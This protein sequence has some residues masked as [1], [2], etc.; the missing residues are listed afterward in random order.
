MAAEELFNARLVRKQFIISLEVL[1]FFESYF[2]RY[3]CNKDR[4][5]PTEEKEERLSG[6]PDLSWHEVPQHPEK[7]GFIKATLDYQEY[8]YSQITH[9]VYSGNMQ[10]HTYQVFKAA[11]SQSFINNWYPINERKDL[12]STTTFLQ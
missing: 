1:T 10:L 3:L 8:A 11:K 9:P 2:E 5:W 7:T 6:R 12:S 4:T